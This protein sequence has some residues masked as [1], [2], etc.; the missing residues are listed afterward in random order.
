MSRDTWWEED[1]NGI[2]LGNHRD[3]R[4][5]SH[6]QNQQDGQQRLKPRA[7]D[8]VVVDMSGTRP[9]KTLLLSGAVLGDLVLLWNTV[10]EIEL[11]LWSTSTP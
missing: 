2:V 1:N 7:D 6:I 4:L 5:V 10:A 9:P 11:R 3:R 8:V